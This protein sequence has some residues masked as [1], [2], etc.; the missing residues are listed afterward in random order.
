MAVFLVGLLE[1]E[2]RGSQRGKALTK[3]LASACFIGLAATAQGAAP[4]QTIVLVALGLS[5][6]G[7]VLLIPHDQRVFRAGILAFLAAHVAFAAAF[8]SLGLHLVA[9]LVAAVALAG[10]A[11]VVGRWLLPHA[12]GLRGAVLAYIAVIS[13]MAAL[14]AG[15][16]AGGASWL[17]AAGATAFFVSDL[18]VARDRFV[19]PGWGNRL[20]GL[21][22]Y[23][24]AQAMLALSVRA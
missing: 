2:R 20:W 23:Y 11:V 7:D 6:L 19:A 5:W 24:A 3:P 1:A 16:T 15:A 22:L 9:T 18:S 4:Y 17:V 21:P 10:L 12:G 14:S 13:V 8:L